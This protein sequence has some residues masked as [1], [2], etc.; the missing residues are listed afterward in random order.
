M[1]A[2]EFEQLGEERE[3]EGKRYLELLLASIIG[4]T[5]GAMTYQIE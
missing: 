4:D 5:K 2:V 1:I 3:D